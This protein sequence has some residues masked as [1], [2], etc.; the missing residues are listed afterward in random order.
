MDWAS[1]ASGFLRRVRTRFSERPNVYAQFCD[2][3][4]DFR[5]EVYK[6][7]I[8]QI[9]AH[10]VFLSVAKSLMDVNKYKKRI[11]TIN[12]IYTINTMKIMKTIKTID[13][14]QLKQSTHVRWSKLG[15]R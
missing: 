13:T 9:L 14:T 6:T 1:T 7:T 12:T 10:C 2:I 3:L 8:T 15:S 5:G 11:S 4:Q